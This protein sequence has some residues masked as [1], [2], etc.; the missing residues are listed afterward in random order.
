[1]ILFLTKTFD[2]NCDK[3]SLSEIF[4]NIIELMRVYRQE[5]GFIFEK[6][7]LFFH[8][9]NVETEDFM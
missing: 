5:R 4:E 1:L 6:L 2:H 7:I 9:L 3:T 8:N